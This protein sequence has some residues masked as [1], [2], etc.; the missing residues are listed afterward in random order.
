MA[1]TAQDAIDR[2]LADLGDPGG[3][4]WDKTTYMLPRVGDALRAIVILVPAAYQVRKNLT[5]TANASLQTLPAGDFLLAKIVR[6]MGT[7]GTAPGRAIRLADEQQLDAVDP[8]WHAATAKAEIKSYCYD[9][10][11]P[12]FFYVYPRP[13]AALQVEA[14]VSQAPPAP[15][16]LGDTA[17][18][19]DIYLNAVVAYLKYRAFDR[20]SKRADR[21]RAAQHYAAFERAL[22]LKKG[23]DQEMAPDRRKEAAEA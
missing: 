1:F 21:D 9:E 23:A 3:T 22:G 14:V 7:S 18:L 4:T 10:K 17:A 19:D 8:N 5:L 6:N 15:G 11:T 13:N 2:A 16:A 20:N 12:G